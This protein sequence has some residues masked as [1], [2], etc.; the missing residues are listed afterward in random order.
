MLSRNVKIKR[1]T[2]AE[3][4]KDPNFLT[5]WHLRN[6]ALSKGIYCFQWSLWRETQWQWEDLVMVDEEFIGNLLDIGGQCFLVNPDGQ[7]KQYQTSM[8]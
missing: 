8:L 4:E 5:L 1:K 2:L 7:I 3:G 6:L